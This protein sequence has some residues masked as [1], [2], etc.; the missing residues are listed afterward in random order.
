[1]VNTPTQQMIQWTLENGGQKIPVQN[2][3]PKDYFKRIGRSGFGVAPTKLITREGASEGLRWRRTRRGG[4]VIV[5]PV[6]ILADDRQA[7]EDKLR[8]LVRLIQD[9]E[10]TPRLVG[11]YPDGHKVYT[12]FHYSSGGDHTY[13]TDTDGRSRVDWTLNLVC[14][15]PY[16]TSDVAISYSIGPANAG[17]GLLPKLSRLQVSSS[18]TIGTVQLENPGDVESYPVWTIRGP[19]DAGFLAQRNDGQSFTFIEALGASDVITVDTLKKTVT[20]QNGDDRYDILGPA[21]K[22]FSIPKGKSNFTVVLTGTSP[23]TLISM[24][25]NPRQELVF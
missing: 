8:A 4:R 21:P 22:L 15:S 3:V 18:Q 14:E 9:D 20:D 2:V 5:F 13:G 6:T 17:R 1:M 25:F 7:V 16:W 10:T 23:A 11:L 24:Y 19:G 12:E